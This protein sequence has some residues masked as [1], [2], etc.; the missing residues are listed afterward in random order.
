MGR[1]PG[2]GQDS[3][4]DDVLSE[5]LRRSVAGSAGASPPQRATSHSGEGGH[6]PQA[7]DGPRVPVV[8]RLQHAPGGRR[9]REESGRF[10]GA[11]RPRPWR[12]QPM[13]QR[14]GT[15]VV[16]QQARR[17]DRRK[18]DAGNGGPPRPPHRRVATDESHH[19]G[20]REMTSAAS[21]AVAKEYPTGTFTSTLT[22]HEAFLV[23]HVIQGKKIL[24]G[25]AYLEMA[26]A[27]VAL[28]GTVTDEQMI[29]L[30]ESVFIQP[31]IVQGECAVETI[32]YPGATGEF[33]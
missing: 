20:V 4:R 15:G 6:R 9:R 7:Q 3:D 30:S 32:V 33:G 27:A 24:P 29:V 18:A 5:V 17:P 25:M 10:P 22:G 14:L 26:R 28:S 16:A 13:G 12:I 8:F 2:T 23:D 1:Y 31:M 21:Q 11:H 19:N